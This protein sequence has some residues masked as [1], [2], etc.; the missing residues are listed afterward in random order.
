LFMHFLSESL[1]R[2]YYIT[3]VFV[4]DIIHRLYFKVLRPLNVTKFRRMA[5]RLEVKNERP[6]T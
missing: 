2:Q 4:S 6:P 5:L 1:W 3:T